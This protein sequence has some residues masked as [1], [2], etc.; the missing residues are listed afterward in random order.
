MMASW[1][2]QEIRNEAGFRDR[3]EWIRHENQ[4]FATDGSTFAI[5]CECGD[6]ACE[7]SI[8]LTI[9]EYEAV[10]DYATRFAVAPNHENPEA[11]YVVGEHPLFT[12]VEKITSTARRIIRETDPRQTPKEGS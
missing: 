10:R 5:V 8:R 12:V 3:N 1:Q 6:A 4:R 7:Q 11:E 2:E 9:L